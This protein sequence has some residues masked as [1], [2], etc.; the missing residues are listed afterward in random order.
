[1][2]RWTMMDRIGGDWEQE[3]WIVGKPVG[4]DAHQDARRKRGSWHMERQ[5]RDCN[6]VGG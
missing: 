4:I 5:G 6:F 2:E 1:M 3:R